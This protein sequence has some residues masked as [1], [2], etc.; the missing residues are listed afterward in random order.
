M[1]MTIEVKI[2]EIKKFNRAVYE[3]NKKQQ[4]CK[5]SFIFVSGSS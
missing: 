2:I 5:L 4:I 1:D 3:N